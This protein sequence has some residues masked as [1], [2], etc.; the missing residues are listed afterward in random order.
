M[1]SIGED[2]LRK[3]LDG[4][5]GDEILKSCESAGYVGLAFYDSG[6]RSIYAKKPIRTPADTTVADARAAVAAAVFTTSAG[7][8]L[9]A[10]TRLP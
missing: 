4:P 6:A 2:G 7:T 5:V 8:T 3:V 1:R 10:I 9:A